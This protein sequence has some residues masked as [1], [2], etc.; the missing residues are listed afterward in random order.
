LSKWQ[1]QQYDGLAEYTVKQT[2]VVSDATFTFNRENIDGVL[3]PAET[4]HQ[5]ALANLRGE[6]ATILK[7]ADML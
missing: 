2:Y 1:L 7:A 5:M 4:I 6:Y 3:V